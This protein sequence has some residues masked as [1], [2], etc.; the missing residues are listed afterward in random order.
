VKTLIVGLGFLKF[1]PR[2][3]TRTK[4]VAGASQVRL[5]FREE[6]DLELTNMTFEQLTRKSGD[7]LSGMLD[8]YLVG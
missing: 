8:E 3:R 2:K 1:E 7:V 6:Y 5:F 4:F